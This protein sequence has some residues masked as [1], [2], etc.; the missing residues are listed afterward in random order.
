MEPGPY[1]DFW[2][3]LDGMG[4]YQLV[5]CAPV[6][7]PKIDEWCRATRAVLRAIRHCVVCW[8]SSGG[9][10]GRGERT[11]ERGRGCVEG[12]KGGEV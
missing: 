4:V 9:H 7:R 10:G 8:F 11:V 2:H 3:L 5:Q 1:R 6:L 12:S